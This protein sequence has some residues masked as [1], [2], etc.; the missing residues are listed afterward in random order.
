MYALKDGIKCYFRKGTEREKQ[1]KEMAYS[2]PDN[3]NP[4]IFFSVPIH[5]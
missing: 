1:V 4:E 5:C 2:E 3:S